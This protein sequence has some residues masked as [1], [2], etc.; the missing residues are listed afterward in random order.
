MQLPNR[1]LL[2]IYTNV[3]KEKMIQLSSSLNKATIKNLPGDWRGVLSPGSRQSIFL[4]MVN[5]GKKYDE[6]ELR[7][8]LG[9]RAPVFSKP[10]ILDGQN[11]N[12]T[13]GLKSFETLR[14]KSNLGVYGIKGQAIQV[15]KLNDKQ[16]KFLP[17]NNKKTYINLRWFGSSFE[18]ITLKDSKKTIIISQNEFVSPNGAKVFL[19]GESLLTVISASHN[20]NVPPFVEVD[21]PFLMDN[22][23]LKI[24]VNA[25]D[26]SGLSSVTLYRDSE[27]L[28][29]LY[30]PPYEWIISPEME[31]HSFQ[32]LAV[33]RSPL[34]NKRLSHTTSW[35]KDGLQS[36]KNK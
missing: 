9:K 5:F 33:D 11:L 15:I 8:S 1:T 13:I 25:A 29:T 4:A 27:V 34:S 21:M 22:G 19:N 2:T 26:R 28:E 14:D 31:T 35:L 17:V 3:H 30:K 36:L 18:K 23:D 10:G 6:S 12:F 20:D 32:A 24:V 16:Y 7:V